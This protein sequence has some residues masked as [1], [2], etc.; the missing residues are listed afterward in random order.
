LNASSASVA[1]R[2][3]SPMQ[4]SFRS[5]RLVATNVHRPRERV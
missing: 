3:A 1:T 4:T 2:S 5:V